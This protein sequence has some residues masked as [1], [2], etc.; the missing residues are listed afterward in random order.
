MSLLLVLVRCGIYLNKIKAG[1]FMAKKQS[2][3]KVVPIRPVKQQKTPA[4]K[5]SKTESLQQQLNRQQMVA[6]AKAKLVT[7]SIDSKVEKLR[8]VADERLRIKTAKADAVI[9]N[10]AATAQQKQD[11]KDAKVHAKEAH[12][13][14]LDQIKLDRDKAIAMMRIDLQDQLQARQN[15]LIAQDQNAG[16]QA[17]PASQPGFPLEPATKAVPVESTGASGDSPVTNQEGVEPQLQTDFEDMYQDS[18]VTDAW[19]D[20]PE[21]D[22]G[23]DIDNIEANNERFDMTQIVHSSQQ[24]TFEGA[25]VKQ[26]NRVELYIDRVRGVNPVFAR[27]LDAELS[28]H[29][30]SGY[31]DGLAAGDGGFLKSIGEAAS[32]AVSSYG[33]FIADRINKKNPSASER[34][35]QKAVTDEMK[36][37]SNLELSARGGS[38]APASGFSAYLP[39]LLAAMVLGGGYLILKK[40]KKSRK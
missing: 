24:P 39:W 20:I 7:T 18:E 15:A 40:K 29:D 37:A 17:V 38:V 5:L 2:A 33:D 28:K 35:K 10:R 26:D 4:P 30:L 8:K 11:A 13:R 34:E 19:G 1:D 31:D 3:A 9:A 25:K 22:I 23:D 16:G 6:D 12:L 27:F 14:E 21:K 36:K 32:K